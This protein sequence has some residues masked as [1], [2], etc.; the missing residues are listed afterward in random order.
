MNTPVPQELQRVGIKRVTDNREGREV[1]LPP[2]A[3]F[4]FFG[5]ELRARFL[6]APESGNGR[7]TDADGI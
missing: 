7:S 3:L 1:Q 6:H 2:G 5:E 4:A